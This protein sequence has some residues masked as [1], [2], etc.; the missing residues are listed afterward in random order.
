MNELLEAMTPRL[1]SREPIDAIRGYVTPRVQEL[2]RALASAI[3]KPMYAKNRLKLEGVVTR[4]A[5]ELDAAREL[6]DLLDGAAWARPVRVELGELLRGAAKREGRSDPPGTRMV[7]VTVAR[8]E[9]AEALVAPRVVMGLAAI[10]AAWVA[11]LRTD[12]SPHIRVRDGSGVSGLDISFEA[13]SGDVMTL[14]V[15]PLLEPTLP[16]AEAAATLSGA[17]LSYMEAP[18]PSPSSGAERLRRAAPESISPA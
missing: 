12:A 11:A 2:D 7:E 15:P 3:P 5:A 1:P 4:L 16:C 10:G 8:T 6:V 9:A 13:R 18:R 14:A 17:K